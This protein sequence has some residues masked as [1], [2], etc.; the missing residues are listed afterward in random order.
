MNLCQCAACKNTGQLERKGWPRSPAG[1]GCANSCS[2]L[3]A[4][5]QSL[6]CYE[7]FLMEKDG[8]GTATRLDYVDPFSPVDD[9]LAKLGR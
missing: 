5:W 6:R 4:V 2:V 3:D 7:A 8:T 1:E 9:I